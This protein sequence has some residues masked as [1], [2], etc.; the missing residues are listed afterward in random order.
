MLLDEEIDCE[1][2]LNR[3]EDN[4]VL[5][6]RQPSEAEH[7]AFLKARFPRRGNQFQDNSVQARKDFIDLILIGTKNI[8][9][10]GPEGKPVE[11]SSSMTDWK[12]KIPLNWKT[13]AAAKFEES[14]ILS[15]ED[16]KKSEG[17][18]K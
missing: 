2:N 13:S 8:Q 6:L 14:E 15:P 16:E 3:G 9:V 5:I 17:P 1:I 18:S 10:K 12:S 7:Q 4:P 11:L